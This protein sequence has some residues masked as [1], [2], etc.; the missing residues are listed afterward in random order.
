MSSSQELL[1][2]T[3]GHFH[4]KS[5]KIRATLIVIYYRSKK[6]W[7]GLEVS[8][9]NSLLWPHVWVSES[10]S[11]PP[12]SNRLLCNNTCFHL[13]FLL[14]SPPRLLFCLHRPAVPLKALKKMLV[15]RTQL[16]TVK[17]FLYFF[18]WYLDSILSEW[19]RG[20]VIKSYLPSLFFFSLTTVQTEVR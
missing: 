10:L 14:P 6:K 2:H 12:L 18:G 17:D 7:L 11:A 20:H 9:L 1:Q 5:H 19:L 13:P 8:F 16:L 15:G 3:A 4:P